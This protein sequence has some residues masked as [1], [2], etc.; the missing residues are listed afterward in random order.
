MRAKLQVVLASRLTAALGVAT[1]PPSTTSA[2]DAAA[3]YL[4]PD[5]TAVTNAGI[6]SGLDKYVLEWADPQRVRVPAGHV[7]VSLLVGGY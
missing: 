2:L 5:T 7:Q 4:T 3:V 6:F 1:H